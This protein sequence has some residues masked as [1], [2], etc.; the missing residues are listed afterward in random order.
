VYVPH[1][2]LKLRNSQN[3]YILG[4]CHHNGNKRIVLTV[5]CAL[6]CLHKHIH[7]ASLGYEHSKTPHGGTLTHGDT[8]VPAKTRWHLIQEQY[9]GTTIKISFAK[10]DVVQM[11]LNRFKCQWLLAPPG[12][13]FNNYVLPTH[14]IYVFCLDLRTNSDYFV[15]SID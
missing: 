13:T 9:P 12:L 11:V 8:R 10:N 4:E 14:C 5:A 6:S 3:A 15:Y 1:Q 2:L 7:T